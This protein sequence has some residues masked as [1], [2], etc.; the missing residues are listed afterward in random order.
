MGRK[1][2]PVRERIREALASM[3]TIASTEVL[4]KQAVDRMSDSERYHALLTLLPRLIREEDRRRSQSGVFADDESAWV[5]ATERRV[6]VDGEDIFLSDAESD[7][8]VK[9]AEIRERAA[10][11]IGGSAERFRVLADTMVRHGAQTVAG[12]PAREGLVALKLQLRSTRQ[13]V[14][15]RRSLNRLRA[16]VD[17][18]QES[19]DLTTARDALE[20]ARIRA[21]AAIEIAQEQMEQLRILRDGSPES[22]QPLIERTSSRIAS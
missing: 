20:A 12:V 2:N 5:S 11:N 15:S 14:A 22:L 4:A 7:Q 6:R 9:L 10:G 18:M 1:P 16:V 17:E 3:P 19:L 13:R 8:V 21:A